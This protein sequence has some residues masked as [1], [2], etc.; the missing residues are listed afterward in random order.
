[1]VCPTDLYGQA[2]LIHHQTCTWPWLL[3][4]DDGGGI[5]DWNIMSEVTLAKEPSMCW[6]FYNILALTIKHH[7]LPHSLT[8]ETVKPGAVLTFT[9]WPHLPLSLWTTQ[10]WAHHFGRRNTTIQMPNLYG[11]SFF[12]SISHGHIS[13]A[14]QH[15]R[16]RWNVSWVDTVCPLLVWWFPVA[17]LHFHYARWGYAGFLGTAYRTGPLISQVETQG[18]LHTL[19][20]SFPGLKPLELHH[21]N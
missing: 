16:P 6:H 1:M 11:Q 13:C 21:V 19:W 4:D 7:S 10:S 2:M 3:D 8:S 15:I 12:L 5:N 9:T 17:G 14:K 18:N 20:Q